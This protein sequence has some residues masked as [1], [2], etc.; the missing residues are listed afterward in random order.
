[1]YRVIIYM[2]FRQLK[3]FVTIAKL[4]S[5]SKAADH[6]FLTQ[7]TISNHIQNLENDLGTILINRSNRKITLTTAGEI[8]FSYAIDILN[9]CDQA[10]FSLEQFQ[11]KIEGTLE[12]ASSSIPGQYILPE[13]LNSFH[14]N[15]PNVNYHLLHYDSRQ[16]VNSIIN[17]EIDFGIVGAIHDTKNLEYIDIMEDRLVFIAP[18]TDKYMPMKEMSIETLKQEKIILREKGSGTRKIFE[19]IL[20]SFDLSIDDFNIVS[21]MESTESIK[22]CVRKGL[23]ISVISKL[24]VVDEIK[25]NLLKSIPMK[26]LEMKRNFYF[27]YHKRRA[28][29]P[30]VDTFKNYV[31]NNKNLLID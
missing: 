13:F 20:L 26:D 10:I 25:L 31:L 3:T 21:Y 15:Y 8:L 7:P 27:V 1:M 12:I 29:S 23:G 4:K 19:D 18:N 22:Q 16:V 2:D 24:A 5:F 17:G 14:K 6:L 9:K 30:L 28:L 11:G